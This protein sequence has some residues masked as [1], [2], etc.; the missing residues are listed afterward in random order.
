MCMACDDQAMFYRAWL[1]DA[2][3]RGVI[4]E[5]ITAE[6]FETYGLK[7]P[8]ALARKPDAAPANAFACDSPE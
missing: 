8:D 5:G 3:A 4:P 1:Q 6:D 2:A 7:V